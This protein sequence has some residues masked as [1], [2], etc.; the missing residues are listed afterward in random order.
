MRLWMIAPVGLAL[1]TAACGATDE[2]RA[3][4]GGLSGAAAGAVVGGPVGAVVGGTAGAVGGLYRDEA[5]QEIAE[6][7]DGQA[8]SASGQRPQAQWEQ[9]GQLTNA[10]VRRAQETL[11]QMGLYDGEIDGLYGPRTM[12]A[13][14]QYQQRQGLPQTAALDDN[15]LQS[16]QQQTAGQPQGQDRGMGMQQ[17]GMQQQDMQQRMDRQERLEMQREQV[18]DPQFPP[19]PESDTGTTTTR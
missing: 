17:Q 6:R 14:E 8:Q 12:R 10:E 4:S 9:G 2:Q 3:A 13:V 15:T 11:Q 5:E 19:P 18:Q 7:T 1:V 16:L